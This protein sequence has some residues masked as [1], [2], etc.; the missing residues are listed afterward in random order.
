V[1]PVAIAYK[2]NVASTT[3][4]RS[5]A[6]EAAP[7]KLNDAY[8]SKQK[9]DWW[10]KP[11]NIKI[12]MS[13]FKPRFRF[14]GPESWY[15]VKPVDFML[16]GAM[17]FSRNREIADIARMDEPTYPFLMWQF[18]NVPKEW[19]DDKANQ[20]AFMKWFSVKIKRAE[21]EPDRWYSVMPV[22]FLN[23]NAR[24]LLKLY[25]NSPYEL[26][27]A[28]Y[29]KAEWLPW[30]FYHTPMAYYKDKANQRAYLEWLG[31]RLNYTK[32]EDWYK[33]EPEKITDNYGHNFLRVM[34]GSHSALVC[35]AFDDYPYLPWLF[36]AVPTGYWNAT[37]NQKAY[38]EWLKKTTGIKTNEALESQHFVENRGAALI[39][40][41][42]RN[43]EELLKSAYGGGSKTGGKP[44]KNDLS[45]QANQRAFIE[46][47]GQKLGFKK[48]DMDAWYEATLQ[49]FLENGG[50]FVMTF[51]KCSVANAVKAAFPEFEWENKRF[52]KDMTI[53]EESVLK[54]ACKHV[55]KT[56]KLQNPEDWHRITVAQLNE[57]GV[58]PIF[59]ANNGIKA[60]LKTVYP[61]FN[62]DD[63]SMKN[64]SA[65]GKLAQRELFL[66][67]K[68][69]FPKSELLELFE[70][71]EVNANLDIYIPE[72]R[73]AFDY[74]G[75]Q[76]YR[77]VGEAGTMEFELDEDKEKLKK[78]TEKKVT[79]VTVPFWWDANKG[80]LVASILEKRPDLKPVLKD[81]V[82]EA[83]NE[84][85]IPEKI[86]R[87]ISK[88]RIM[89][90]TVSV[91]MADKWPSDKDPVG[92]WMSEKYDGVRGL[93]NGVKMMSRSGAEIPL[94]DT[95]RALLP[96]YMEVDGEFTIG[97]GVF[98][99]TVTLLYP[100]KQDF[101]W[102][103][104]GYHVFDLPTLNA[105]FE[106]RVAKIKE[107]FGPVKETPDKNGRIQPVEQIKV[108]SR[109]QFNK[110]CEDIVNN[111]GEGVMLR[112]AQSGYVRGALLHPRQVE[113]F[114]RH[115]GPHDCPLQEAGLPWSPLRAPQR[116]PDLCEVH[117]LRLRESPACRHR[118]D[119]E[120]L[121]RV[122][123]DW[124]AQARHLAPRTQGHELGRRAA[125]V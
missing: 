88:W 8:F 61:N 7:E 94:P 23:Y 101:N 125:R 2:N 12:F 98:N 119:R 114:P 57:I 96:K 43:M 99:T 86:T 118:P 35:N 82:E 6:T 85:K 37:E 44:D 33:L 36:S 25:N 3:V 10:D 70:H 87:S 20:Y 75:V 31:K 14:T 22:E 11:E 113:A 116:C 63:K 92:W 13:Y 107:M 41:F 78:C 108:T 1:S 89:G 40:K 110:F 18:H 4:A 24:G 52:A 83:V 109:E 48:G 81:F 53:N 59:R 71:P 69:L 106:E 28:L 91:M 105:P 9:P 50:H 117:A 38:I 65:K 64:R 42:D 32:P 54:I 76:H 102:E 5:N 74:Q 15:K 123:V 34:E 62:W 97:R 16:A 49:Q 73:L 55:E 58:Y 29:P 84:G 80:A 104:M 124:Q 122:R 27:K 68:D 47:L 121:W 103:K 95:F 56:F 30:R 90:E 72:Y 60:V 66:A 120:A 79:L 100:R 46:D 26:L 21:G 67:I 51:Q 111:N 19:W 77:D 93:W 45:V 115:G 17:K 112:K 39:R